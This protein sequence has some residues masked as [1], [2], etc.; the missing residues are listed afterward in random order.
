MGKHQRTKGHSFERETAKALRKIYPQ[1]RRHLEYQDGENNGV[2]L[3][4]TGP[5]RI[6]CKRAKGTVPINKIEEIRESG[7]PALV[8]KTDRKPAYIT[9]PFEDFVRILE[10]VGEA[11]I[12]G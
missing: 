9:I 1:A 7:I 2:D 3:R 11:F 6:Q 4:N 10:D 8:S 12:E 5:F